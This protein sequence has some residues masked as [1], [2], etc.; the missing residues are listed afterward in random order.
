MGKVKNKKKEMSKQK[1]VPGGEGKKLR[2]K[3]EEEAKT[4]KQR[5]R[6][7]VGKGRRVGSTQLREGK[8][9][10]KRT[11]RKQKAELMGG[12]EEEDM[13]GQWK[14]YDEGREVV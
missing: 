7:V 14:A 4:G 6:T 2:G 10:Q 12:E 5:N 3:I 8:R 1:E 13:E 11:R 9:K